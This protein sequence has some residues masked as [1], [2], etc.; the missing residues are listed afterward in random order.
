MKSFVISHLKLVIIITCIVATT[1]IGGIITFSVI[2]SNN[3]VSIQS[4]ERNKDKIQI[5]IVANSVKIRQSKEPNS[6]VIGNVYKNE[7]Y[8]VISEDKESQYKWLEI[9]TSNGIKGY[10]VGIE[11]YVKRLETTIIIEEEQKSNDKPSIDNE[12]TSNNEEKPNNNQ[13]EN[14]SNN[15]QKPNNSNNTNNDNITKTFKVN[16]NT[17][18][19]NTIEPKIVKEWESVG[20]LPTP[21]K[22]GYIFQYWEYDNGR[23]NDKMYLILQSDI[24]LNAIWEKY[25][26]YEEKI[27]ARETFYSIVEKYGYTKDINTG[28]SGYKY[29]YDYSL[30]VSIFLSFTLKDGMYISY[31]NSSVNYTC[32]YD[33]NKNPTL[34]R[35]YPDNVSHDKMEVL[36]PYEKQLFNDVDK[37]YKEYISTGFTIEH[38]EAIN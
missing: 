4:N 2:K 34:C 33:W 25:I 18:G 31:S 14:K 26:P 23:Y 35:I 1:I 27:K 29:L 10:I 17:N 8:S 20:S 19:G 12:N 6:Q 11:A 15:N 32:N 13:T 7:I 9:E 24:T 37:I 22:N 38:L 5:E 36:F 21:T 28:K 3:N 30:G 16:F